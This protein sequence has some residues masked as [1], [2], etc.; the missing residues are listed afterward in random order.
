MKE[1]YEYLLRPCP[2]CG[3]HR[4][5][6]ERDE[7]NQDKLAIVCQKCSCQT[8]FSDFYPD[9]VARWNSRINDKSEANIRPFTPPPKHQP[10][11]WRAW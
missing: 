7:K 11:H 8:M 2:M 6:V 10:G 9:I 1:S 5:A 3:S 4:L